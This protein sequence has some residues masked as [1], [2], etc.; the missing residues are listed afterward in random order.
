MSGTKEMALR[1]IEEFE[2]SRKR[3][4]E[5]GDVD[6][7]LTRTKAKYEFLLQRFE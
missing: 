1:E 3:T 2:K 4:P 7:W 6:Q 5:S